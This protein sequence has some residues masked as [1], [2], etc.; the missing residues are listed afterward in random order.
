LALS[1]EKNSA[2]G[3]KLAKSVV[4]FAAGFLDHQFEQSYGL[5]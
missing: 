5:T 2:V 3:P 1:V 4:A